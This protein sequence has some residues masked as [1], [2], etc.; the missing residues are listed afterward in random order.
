MKEKITQ[1]QKNLLWIIYKSVRDNGY[2]PS[3]EE[4]KSEMNISSKQAVTDYLI[5]L[6]KKGLIE[7]GVKSA[8]G[9]KILPLGYQILKVNPL[10][11]TLGASY[12]GYFTETFTISGSWQEISPEIKLLNNEVFVIEVNGDS[13][14]NAG[15]LSG[16]KLLIQKS[17]TFKNKDIVLA[18]TNEGTTIKRFIKQNQPPFIY[19]KPE[20]PK[21][22]NI[23]FT[24]DVFMQGKVIG[25]FVAGHWQQITQRSFYDTDRKKQTNY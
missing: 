24:D 23:L 8:R 20:N 12:A 1:R 10:A 2:P 5:S 19:L 6:E 13:M 4:I 9:I 14:V 15:I 7:R 22:K 21:Y 25:K 18:C 17:E 16:D 3:F 11:P